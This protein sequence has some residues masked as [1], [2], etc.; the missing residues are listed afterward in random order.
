M[1]HRQG[2]FGGLE[3]KLAFRSGEGDHDPE[4]RECEGDPR[5]LEAS[6]AFVEQGGGEHR[7]ERRRRGND[8]G[9][10]P[11]GHRSI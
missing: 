7:D 4:S 1:G 6:E 8:Q 2:S 9:G 5:G 3:T 10:R 11:G